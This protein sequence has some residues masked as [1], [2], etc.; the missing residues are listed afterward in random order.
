M[1]RARVVALVVTIVTLFSHLAQAQD[2]SDREWHNSLSV[3][4]FAASVTGETRLTGQPIDADLS[5]ILD[6]LQMIFMGAY[7]ITIASA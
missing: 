6:N 7:R 3:Y 5:D 2:R 1:K 4:G